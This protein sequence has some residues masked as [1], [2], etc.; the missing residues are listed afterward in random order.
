MSREQLAGGAVLERRE[1]EVRRD[2]SAGE[3]AGKAVAS[4]TTPTALTPPATPSGGDS[5]PGYRATRAK[6]IAAFA[7]VYLIWG[8]TYLA[9]RFAIESMPP[10]L[11]AAV[12]FVIAGGILYVW[13]RSRGNPRPRKVEWRSALIIGGLLLWG[14]NGAVVWAEQ[15]I[16]SGLAALLVATVPLWMVAIDAFRPGGKQPG[17]MVWAGVAGG[18]LGLVLLIGPAELAGAQRAD[19]GGIL[20][21]LFGSLVWAAGSLYSRR[22]PLPDS[23]RLGTGME[24]LAGGVLLGLFSLSVGEV[25]PLGTGGGLAADFDLAAVTWVSWLSLAYLIVFGA[26]VAFSAYVW[27]LRV[28]PAAKV[29]TYAYVNPVVALILGW[30]LAGEDLNARTLIAAAVILGSVGLIVSAREA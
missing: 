1:D 10:F 3:A 13:A 4:A 26:I 9:I 2:A 21:V 6:V 24:M 12:R 28:V 18:L 11:M 23:P 17:W 8:S 30:L 29:A 27:L 22:A 5:Q 16:D 25:G 14:G 19:L 7:A 15:H 20:A